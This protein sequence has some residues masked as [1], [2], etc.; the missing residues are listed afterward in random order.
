[1]SSSR[2]AEF[3]EVFRIPLIRFCNYYCTNR[4]RRRRRV[5]ELL[6][7]LSFSQLEVSIQFSFI[8]IIDFAEFHGHVIQS[9]ILIH[10]QK[11]HGEISNSSHADFI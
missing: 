6:L 7:I 5:D 3:D 11:V 9:N 10:S 4:R 8:F 2:R 1:M